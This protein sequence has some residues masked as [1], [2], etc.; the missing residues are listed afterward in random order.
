VKSRCL[1]D[2][3]VLVS[4]LWEEHS[5]HARANAWFAREN[6]DVYGC[7]FT[8]LS[9]LRV[10]MADKTIAASFA[11][12]QTVLAQFIAALGPR[13]HFIEKLPPASF[14]Q[15]QPVI[16]QKQVSDWYLCELAKLHSLRLATLDTGIKH[17]QA[18]LIA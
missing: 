3:N 13:Y 2:V 18:K 12:A 16:N 4:L 5:L 17:P 14:L 1:L 11:D 9:F 7:I 6:P 15:T 10:S 8:E